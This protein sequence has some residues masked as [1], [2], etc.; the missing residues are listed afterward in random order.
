[1]DGL[2]IIGKWTAV[3]MLLVLQY[4]PAGSQEKE[5]ALTMK[6]KPALTE[7][8]EPVPPA[9]TPG[10]GTAP[11]S[12][13]VV[14]FDGRD[15]SSWE[16]AAGDGPAPWKVED[17]GSFRIVPGTGFIQTRQSFGDIQ[18]HIEWKVPP[19]VTGKGQGR[20]NSGIFIQ[21]RYE[22]QVLDGYDNST[23]VNGQAASVYKQYAP[24][25]NACKPPGE[26]QAFDIVYIAPRFREVGTLFAPATLTLLH[27]GVLVQNHVAI[28]GPTKYRGLP[29]YSPHDLR[30][31]ISIQDHRQAVIFRNIWVREL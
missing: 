2:H 24:L 21:K 7:K 10:E 31:P 17:D 29:A 11:P 18:L 25:V 6:W 5:P 23:Y 16:N 15:L 13:A 22:I 30:Q 19:D 9:V 14:L 1:M 3:L 8:W 20:G 27:N 28:G 4:T 12:D 26:W